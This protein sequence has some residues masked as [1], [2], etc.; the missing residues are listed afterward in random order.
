LCFL[1]VDI[2]KLIR[3]NICAPYPPRSTN[4]GNNLLRMT[5][6]RLLGIQKCYT[7]AKLT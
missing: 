1:V 7:L 4:K 5:T 2:V 6:S 3:F